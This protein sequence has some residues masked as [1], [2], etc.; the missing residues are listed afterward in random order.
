MQLFLGFAQGFTSYYE[1]TSRGLPPQADGGE[2][3]DIEQE[4][5]IF[6]ITGDNY[7]VAHLVADNLLLNPNWELC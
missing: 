2:D 3:E 7:R 1:G 6:K 4:F 5:H